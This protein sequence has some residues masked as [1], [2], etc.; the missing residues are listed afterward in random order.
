MMQI[1]GQ[2]A[3]IVGIGTSDDFG[4][5]L[6]RSPIRLQSEAFRAA[7]ADAGLNKDDVDGFA[8]AHG[9]PTG[10][11][12]EEFTAAAG[13]RVRYVEQ[14]WAH[15]RW[16]TGL[17]AHAAFAV[18]VGLADIVAIANTVTTRRGYARHL[19]GLG[20]APTNEGLRDTGG[21]HGEWSVH[22][23]DTPGAATALVAQRYMEKYGAGARDLAE[24]CTSFRS[25]A[26]RNPMATMRHKPMTVESYFNEPVIAGPF[27]RA[28]FALT[29]EGS[30][31]LLVTT[32]DRARDL[33]QP[34]ANIAGIQSI[35]S[36]RDDYVMFSRPGLGSGFGNEGLYAPAP[37][38]VYAMADVD[39][40]SVDGLYAYDS[41][42]S[43][44]WMVAERFG[45]CTEGEAPS[46]LR[47][48]AFGDAASVPVNTNGG[49]LS[50]GDYTGY[51]HIVEMVRQLRGQAGD[52]QIPSAEVL[53]WATPWGDSLVLSG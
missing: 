45:F 40:D 34:V 2:S 43:N 8:T 1:N 23:I 27:R 4:F 20:G 3:C 6:G 35:Q 9:S 19:D 30:T 24:I 11:D 17:I 46:W 44:I 26:Q 36:S 32:H 22:G 7:L 38:P 29:S 37:Q 21:G 16:A 39:R 50:E 51:G 5:D 14:A 10:V 18:T 47:A 41:F 48:N 33:R 53:Q 49:M 52:R 42:S 15:G 31:C 13:L 12:Y 25:H 28:D